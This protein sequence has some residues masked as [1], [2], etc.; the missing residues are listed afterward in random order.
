MSDSSPDPA[1]SSARSVAELPRQ[2]LSPEL[3]ESTF[4]KACRK[5]QTAYTPVWLMR[6]AG[7]YMKEFRDLR[8]K[9]GFLELCKSPEL[10]C[11]VTV[12]AQETIA[13]DAAIIFADILLPL[14]AMGV[15]LSYVKGEGPQ[16][17]RPFRNEND[18]SAIPDLN[19]AQSLSYVLDAIRLTR[20]ALKPDIPLLGFAAC[21]FTLASYLIEGGSSRNFENTKTLMYSR[22][23]LWS[24]L[25]EKLVPFSVDYLNAQIDAGAQALQVFDSWVGCLSPADYEHYVLSHTKRLIS[26]VRAGTPVIHFGTGTGNLLALMKEAG[27]DVIGLDWRVEISQAWNSLGDVAV[28][29]NLDPCV[30]FGDKEFIEKSCRQILK[31]VRGKKGHIFNLGHGVLP[32]TSVDNVK[33]LIDFVHRFDEN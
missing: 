32:S 26:G 23:D 31:T 29:G 8:S 20:A 13:A 2:G 28:Q 11:E 3:A 27:G 5:E 18:L 17:E 22:P 24:A 19:A 7:R 9:V 1:N 33:A 16:I 30:L 12:H 10:C 25:M 4:L 21:P 14:D 6:Q 15:G